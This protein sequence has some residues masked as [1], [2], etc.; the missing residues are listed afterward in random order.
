[1]KKKTGSS[2]LV[3]LVLLLF[4]VGVLWFFWPELTSWLG[5]GEKKPAPAPTKSAPKEKISEEDRRKLEEIL[6]KRQQ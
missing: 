2:K 6:K 5:W 4:W 3:L 1:M